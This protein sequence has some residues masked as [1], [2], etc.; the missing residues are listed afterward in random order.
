MQR[1]V[2]PAPATLAAPRPLARPAA[3]TVAAASLA[4]ALGA[5]GRLVGARPPRASVLSPPTIRVVA[6]PGWLLGPLGGALPHLTTDP[7][8]LH[9]DYTVALAVLFVAWLVAWVTAKALPVAAVAASVAL[10][11]VVFLLGPPQPLTDFFNYIVYGRMAAHGLNPYTHAPVRGAH[12]AA[13]A[14]SNWHHLPSPYG[15]LFTLLCAPI[16][17]LP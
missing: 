4:A 16:S 5:A 9:T 8:R 6:A 1:A 3:A 2:A 10:A 17:L 14:L 7:R 13:Y 12:G 15:P 11:Q